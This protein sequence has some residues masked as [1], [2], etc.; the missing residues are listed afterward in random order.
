M[1][2]KLNKKQKPCLQKCSKAFTLTEF[3]NSD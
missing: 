1:G 2:L 3:N